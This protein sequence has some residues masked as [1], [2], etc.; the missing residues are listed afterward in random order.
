[1]RSIRKRPLW[2]VLFGGLTKRKLL[3][4]HNIGV[5]F[6][7]DA[8]DTLMRA[9]SDTAVQHGME[10]TMV[11]SRRWISATAD[12]PGYTDDGRLLKLIPRGVPTRP[13]LEIELDGATPRIYKHRESD[14]T[15][16]FKGRA[17]TATW[18][19]GFISA[20]SALAHELLSNH[21]V[22]R[23]PQRASEPQPFVPMEWAALHAERHT[24]TCSCGGRTET[25]SRCF[26]TGTYQV[27][28]LGNAI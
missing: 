24:V 10:A 20:N 4:H 28:G 9:I 14:L 25:C 3:G 5:P 13:L 6:H 11:G 22:P 18:V 21:A 2:L 23:T 19:A 7:M 17:V 27:D 1:M 12:E 26:G 16:R 15:A 8:L